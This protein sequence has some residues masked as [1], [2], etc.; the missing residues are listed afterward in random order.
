M[1]QAHLHEDVAAR[2]VAAHVATYGRGHPMCKTMRNL[3]IPSFQA[4]LRLCTCIGRINYPD[5]GPNP[6]VDSDLIAR[7][8]QHTST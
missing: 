6:T 5:L 2:G 4:V 3:C 8:E 7:W 1:V